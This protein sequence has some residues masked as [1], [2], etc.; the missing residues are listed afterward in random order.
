[1]PASL[2]P[3]VRTGRGIALIEALAQLIQRLAIS[4]LHIIGDIYDR[5]PQPDV[6]MDDAAGAA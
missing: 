3:A 5:G 6:I 1:M 4:Q 2:M